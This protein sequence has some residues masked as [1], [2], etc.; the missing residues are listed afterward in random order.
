M[1]NVI[2]TSQWYDFPNASDMVVTNSKFTDPQHL[3]CC[4]NNKRRQHRV[5]TLCMLQDHDLLDQG[6]VSYHFKK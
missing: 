6:L 4:L 1:P 5:L 3:F 2:Y